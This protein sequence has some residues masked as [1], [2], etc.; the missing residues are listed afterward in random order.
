[1]RYSLKLC[2]VVLEN[3]S[4]P[5]VWII[6]SSDEL[7]LFLHSASVQPHPLWRGLPW[8][9]YPKWHPCLSSCL[10][11][12]LLLLSTCHHQRDYFFSHLLSISFYYCCCCAVAQLCPTLCNFVYCS[13]P[14]FPVLHHLLE[15]AQTPVHW[16][17][18]TIQ[19]VWSTC[20]PKDSQESSLGSAGK[21]SACNAGDLG[22]IPGLGRSPGEWKGYPLQY[23]GLEN[24]NSPWGHKESDTTEWLSL[25]S[26]TV[27]KNQFCNLQDFCLLCSLLY[28]QLLEHN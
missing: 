23:S 4:V 7:V 2:R 19:L 12:L 5:A 3:C 10:L 1:M 14:G 15:F 21:E 27:R 28:L 17:G 26:T 8:R 25:S 22:S 24:S 6:L 20:C 18:D 13:T 16:V 9:L 11:C